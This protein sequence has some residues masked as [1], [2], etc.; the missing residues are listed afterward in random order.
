[1]F[2]RSFYGSSEP[3]TPSHNETIPSK[4]VPPLSPH[5]NLLAGTSTAALQCCSIS[6]MHIPSRRGFLK[7]TLG[8]CWT[9]AALLEQ[10]VFRADLARAQASESLP[11]LFD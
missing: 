7:K 5:I 3:G 4:P 10:A 8:A 1:M 6:S 9:G 11:K 2:F